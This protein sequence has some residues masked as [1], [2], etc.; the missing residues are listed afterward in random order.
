M[1]VSIY[2]KRDRES[3]DVGRKTTHK[4][5]FK[6]LDL[7]FI[8]RIGDQVVVR[9]G[10]CTETVEEVIYSIHSNHIQIYVAGY[11]RDNEY[12]EVT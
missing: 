8:P 11:D 12:P 4:C 9:K 2:V 6:A 1:K 10:F 5:I 7:P 3:V